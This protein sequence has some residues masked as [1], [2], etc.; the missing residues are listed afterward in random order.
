MV[1]KSKTE[2]RGVGGYGLH[3]TRH[4]DLTRI[5]TYLLAELAMMRST[6]WGGDEDFD[7][8]GGSKTVAERRKGASS[9]VEENGVGGTGS[10]TYGLLCRNI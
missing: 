9:Q 5:E 7:Q 10:R 3:E 6:P 2:E 4:K 1:S 8:D